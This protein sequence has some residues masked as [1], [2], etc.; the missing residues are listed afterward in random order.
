M[1]KIIFNFGLLIFYILIVISCYF[2]LPKLCSFLIR[3]SLFKPRNYKHKTENKKIVIVLYRLVGER[4]INI[5]RVIFRFSNLILE[6]KYNKSNF[7]LFL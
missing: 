2:N 5:V 6:K 1:K 4:D 7:L 3:I